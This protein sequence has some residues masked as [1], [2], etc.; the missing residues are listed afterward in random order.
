[1]SEDL[2]PSQLKLVIW[3]LDGTFWDGILSE[4]EIFVKPGNIDRVISLT[5]RGIMNSICSKNNFEQAKS[6]LEDLGIWDLFVFP[7]IDWAPKGMSVGEI[8]S[9]MGLRAE[10]CIFIDDLESNREEVAATLP[11]LWVYHPDSILDKLDDPSFFP[12]KDDR[13]RQRLAHYKTLASRSA[14]ISSAKCSNVEFLNESGIEI[15]F[16]FEP[17]RSLERVFELIE[18]T[19]QLNFTKKRLTTD[20]DLR[21]FVEKLD[22]FQT[23]AALIHCR[24]RFGDYGPVGFFLMR[25]TA[26]G[27]SLEHFLFSC[28]TLNMGLEGYVY[29]FLRRPKITIAKPVAY[30]LDTYGGAPWIRRR[31]AFTDHK[32]GGETFDASKVLLLGPCHLLQ[33]SSYLGK[34]T[35]D[36]LHEYRGKFLIKFDCPGFFLSS[37]SDVESSSF[38]EKGMTWSKDDYVRFHDLLP[39]VK[40]VVL[41]LGDFSRIDKLAQVD[42]LTLRPFGEDFENLTCVN[43][44]SIDFTRRLGL[45]REVVD[46]VS[47]KTREDA[48]I[49]VLNRAFSR[50]SAKG[51]LATEL[52]FDHVL[53]SIRDAKV[54]V[55]DCNSLVNHDDFDG[56]GHMP[57]DA[58]FRLSE[59]VKGRMAVPDYQFDYGLFHELLRSP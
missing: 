14:A 24:D 20:E 29:E 7:R 12:G 50:K 40:T 3:D 57:R 42:G 36:F 32:S 10:N 38:L 6:A 54:R 34:G 18:R 39:S 48:E 22:F 4:T 25:T 8:V 46:F 16:D 11:G 33:A 59:I 26:H 55:I 13:D 52:A 41:D 43:F 31:D 56:G 35:M 5:N 47:R 2:Y 37:K 15:V 44:F 51:K 58:Y 1:M 17:K 49:L 23:Q 30:D 19:N 28:R 45:V 27:R 21:D 53:R 9:S